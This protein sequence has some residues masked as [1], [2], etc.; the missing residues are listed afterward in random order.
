MVAI[1]L[2]MKWFLCVYLLEKE[3]GQAGVV[4]GHGHMQ[5]GHTVLTLR[6]NRGLLKQGYQQ[7]YY[8]VNSK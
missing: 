1:F 8:I 7:Y 3:K 2:I 5:R 6:I 4:V